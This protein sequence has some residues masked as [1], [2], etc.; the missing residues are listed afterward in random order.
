MIGLIEM[1]V[2]TIIL[3]L[4]V[5]IALLEFVNLDLFVQTNSKFSDSRSYIWHFTNGA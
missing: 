5:S 1:F 2:F 4:T 3:H